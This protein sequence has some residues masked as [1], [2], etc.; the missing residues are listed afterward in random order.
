ML[1]ARSAMVFLLGCIFVSCNYSSQETL[2]STTAAGDSTRDDSAQIREAIVHAREA[3]RQGT[4]GDAP[5][6]VAHA[7]AAFNFA[8]QAQKSQPTREHLREVTEALGQAIEEGRKGDAATAAE[9]VRHAIMELL[10][11]GDSRTSPTTTM[12]SVETGK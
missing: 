5:E 7:E 4:R 6:L 1:A 10:Q 2:S 3:E 11:A 8:K 9:R 12:P